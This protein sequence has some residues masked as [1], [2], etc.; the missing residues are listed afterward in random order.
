[1]KQK[2]IAKNYIYNLILTTLNIIFPLITAPYLSLILGADNIGKVNYA[3]SIVNWFV[4]FAAFGIPRYG[5]REIARNRDSKKK[6]SNAF[7]NLLIIQVILSIVSIIIY[8]ILILSFKKFNT[9]IGLY[10]C[11]VLMIILSI[12]SIDWFYQ[13]IEEYGYITVR[14]IIVKI[15]T[16]ILMFLMIKNKD[17]YIRY[18]ILNIVGLGFNNILN[19]IH[20]FKY[21]DRKIYKKKIIYYIKELKVYF[22]TTLVV[23]LYTQLDQIIVGSVSQKDLALYIRSSTI[24]GIG[25]NIT[26][27][28]IT[29]LIPRVSYLVVNNYVEFKNIITKSINYIYILALP[30]VIGIF[31]LSEEIM[32]VLG[33][34]EFIPAASSLKIICI[35]VLITSIGT[36]QINQILLPL[37]KENIAFKIQTFGC[38]FSIV[39]NLILIPYLSYIGAAVTRVFTESILLILSGIYIKLKLKDIRIKYITKSLIK[40]I[41]AS[42]FMIISI[43]VIKLT[44]MSPILKIFTSVIIAPIIYFGIIILLK[45]CFMINLIISIKV[46]VKK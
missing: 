28:L 16:I 7:W 12:F 19:Y 14:N 8:L 38:V 33:G 42:I 34:K 30:C 3:T 45:D 36:W 44:V 1:M 37:K 4:L 23:A 43:I 17:Q 5:V 35:V 31:T 29:I 39:L 21:I 20:V 26:N 6:R 24:L 15:I 25:L 9:D 27:S 10:L 46:K 41:I 22:F 13:G 40:Y 2:S 32:F 11:M 18:A